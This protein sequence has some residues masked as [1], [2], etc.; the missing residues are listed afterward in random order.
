MLVTARSRGAARHGVAVGMPLAEARAL[1]TSSAGPAT[2]FE[3]HDPRADRA[4]LRTLAVWCQRFSPFVAVEEREPPDSLLL[5]ITGCGPLFGGEEALA[6]KLIDAFHRRR[7][8]VRAAVADTIGA[9]WALAHHGVA[10]DWQS[11]DYKSAAT[12]VPPGGQAEALVPLAVEAL[13]LSCHVLELLHAFDIR[14]IGQLLALPRAELPAHFGLEVVQRLDQ[15]LGNVPEL[16]TPERAAEPVEASWSIEPPTADRRMIEAIFGHLLEQVLE[17]LPR[18]VGVQRLLCSLRTTAGEPVHVPVS[19]L[20]ASASARRLLELARLHFERV[21]LPAEVSAMTVAAAVVAPLEFHQGQIFEDDAGPDRWRRLQALLERL[22]SRLGER[23]VLRPRLWPDVQPEF[24]WR[25]EPWMGQ[26]AVVSGE[27]S[28]VS[29]I[30]VVPL[31]THHSPLCGKM[32]PVCL[33]SPPRAIPV[34]SI[35]PGGPPVRFEWQGQ[36]QMVAHYRGPERI[37]TGWWRGP[38][39]RRDYYLVETTTGQRFW[40]FRTIRDESW[41]LHGDFA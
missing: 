10:A 25:A 27:W 15:A 8:W 2:R 4:V 24:A 32:R 13:R 22:S 23:C 18:H 16:L 34:M 26:A 40:L 7:Y 30:D 41:F 9:A 33:P 35:V 28:V 12:L 11:A 31:T 3:L 37:E 20:R 29:G 36:S 5:D 1:G 17:R 21:R 6:R 14:R 38:D 19:L 39:V